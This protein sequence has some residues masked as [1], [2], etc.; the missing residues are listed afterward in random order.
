MVF[1][2]IYKIRQNYLSK[3]NNYAKLNLGEYYG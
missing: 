2:F 3:K 1:E